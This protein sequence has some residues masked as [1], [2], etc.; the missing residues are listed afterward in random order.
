M[1]DAKVALV[2]GSGKR[3]IGWHVAQALA[4][5]GYRL[6]IHYHTS[7]ADAQQT[8]DAFLARGIEAAAFAADLTVETQVQALVSEVVARFERIDALVNCAGTWRA[9]RLEDVNAADVRGFFDSNV[10]STFLCCQQVGLLMAGQAAGG[11]IVNFGDWATERPYKNYA[12]YFAAKGAIAALTRCMAVELAA[13]NPQV[14]VNC[15]QPGPVMLPADLPDDERKKAI[16][17]TLLKREGR[18]DNAAQAVLHFLENDFITGVCLS[19]DGG[20]T[21]YGSGAED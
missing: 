1:S 5:R 18:P 21:I 19:V 4:D 9:K 7:A 11:A 3:R 14:R 20:R 10:L 15:V 6:A 2:T 13:R 17:G 16:D 12:A 8:V